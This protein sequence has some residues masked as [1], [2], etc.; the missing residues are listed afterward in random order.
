MGNW[1]LKVDEE[2]MKA[3]HVHILEECK[4]PAVNLLVL[5][6]FSMEKTTKFVGTML[7]KIWDARY[8]REGITTIII[9]K[10]IEF[11]GDIRRE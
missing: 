6:D 3:L 11:Q 9:C 4:L 8:D 10:T 5:D 2:K 7:C 1:E